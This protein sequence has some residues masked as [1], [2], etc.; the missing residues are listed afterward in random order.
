MKSISDY[1][2]ST[3]AM[4]LYTFLAEAVVEERIQSFSTLMEWVAPLPR[5]ARFNAVIPRIFKLIRKLHW[6]F[7]RDID[8]ETYPKI[9]KEVVIP[10]KELK[11]F[12]DLK[13][14][15]TI[16][17]VYVGIL[18]LHGYTRFC[19]KNKNNLSMLQMLDDIIQ[20]DLFNIAKSYNVVFQRRQGDEMVLVGASAC[21]VLAVTLLIIDT[22]AKRRTF[23]V[24]EQANHRT[25]YKIILEEMHVS[26]GIAGGKKFTPFIITK[27]GDL[28]GGVINTAARLQ[29]RAN[30]L[31]GSHSM[32]LV[33]RTVYTNFT[34][35][36]KNAP[37]PF[38]VKTPIKFFDSGWI[39]F[40]G[41]SVAVHE[42][43]YT[44]QDMQKLLY[45]AQMTDLYRAIEGGLWKDGIYIS[46]LSLLSKVLR[47][48]PKLKIEVTEQG[49][50]RCLTN[51]DIIKFIQDTLS[52]FRITQDYR[53]ALKNLE[54]LVEYLDAI[55]R[56]D[57]LCL[58]YAHS[59]TQEYRKI[60]SRY[61]AR[62][63]TKIEEKVPTVLPAKY[64]TLYEE[65]RRGAEIYQKLQERL[66]QTLTPLEISLL[67]SSVIDSLQQHLDVS[68]H[69]GK[70]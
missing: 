32:I 49:S 23:N 34:N 18:D 16:S 50:L 54:T 19:E 11:Q 28:S 31:S 52:T 45:E 14:N 3:S 55:P 40:K 43:L 15:L 26:A 57:R 22:F 61:E 64:R 48:M 67:W 4:E 65:G 2:S 12:G 6:G 41:I 62:I 13:R 17:D 9:W 46:L 7:F 1:T 5:D 37:H 21:D 33:S 70:K 68:I 29:G 25:G 30:E 10:H 36:M 20:V 24:K 27:D 60:L 58:E 47:T 53:K 69:S 63:D 56:F 44:E 51:E 66:Y 8:P 59:I 39:S 42:V 35:E 38:F